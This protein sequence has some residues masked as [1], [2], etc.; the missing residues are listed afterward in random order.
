MVAGLIADVVQLIHFAWI[1]FAIFGALTIFRWRWMIWVHP[2]VLVWSALVM[3]MGWL[4]PL[5]PMEVHFREI[6]GQQGYEGGFIEH[7]IASL[8]YPAGLTRGVQISLGVAL[9]VFNVLVYALLYRY[10]R[11]KD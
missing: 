6:A 10:R 11:F 8:I 9:A 2:P 1:V 7:Y 4:C 3:V 5:T